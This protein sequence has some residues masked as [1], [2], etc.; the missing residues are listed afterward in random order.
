VPYADSCTDLS[1]IT[2]GL[3]VPSTYSYAGVTINT[4]TG[5]VKIDPVITKANSASFNQHGKIIN[6]EV[7]RTLGSVVHRQTI[8]MQ[9][10]ANCSNK[11]WASHLVSELNP[12]ADKRTFNSIHEY[13]GR[14]ILDDNAQ[15]SAW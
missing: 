5:R 9:I 12:P 3:V 1:G 7:T 2:Y 14:G 10:F 11:T 15:M 8:K 6:F 4:S 13:H